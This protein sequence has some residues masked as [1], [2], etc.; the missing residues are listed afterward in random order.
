M[1]TALSVGVVVEPGVEAGRTPVPGPQV[2]LC[3]S[4]LAAPG[5][6]GGPIKHEKS[7]D[8]QLRPVS[9]QEI[10]HP[11]NLA[12]SGDLIGVPLQWNLW[13]TASASDSA[14]TEEDESEHR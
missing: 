14:M 7:P 2:P 3:E 9:R 8:C 6:G 10:G 1:D 12:G 11:T 13:T 4:G 5:R